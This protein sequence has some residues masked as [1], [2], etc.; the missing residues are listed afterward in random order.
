MANDDDI[1]R[2]LREVEA[3]EGGRPQAQPPAQAANDVARQPADEGEKRSSR[4][5]WT[6]VSAIGGGVFGLVTGTVLFFVPWVD[7]MSTGIGAAVGGAIIGLV[8]G[9]PGW[10]GKDD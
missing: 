5:T 8:S 7:P 3:L 2:L 6:G 9:P 10:F 4:V 1:E